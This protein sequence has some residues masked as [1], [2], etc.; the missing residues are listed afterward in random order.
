MAS[1]RR[2]IATLIIGSGILFLGNG[3]LVTLLPVRAQLEGYS[4]TIIGVMGTV[5]FAGFG[6]GC[7]LGPRVVMQVGHIRCFSGFAA[8][9]A[10]SVL[11]YPLALDPLAW[12]LLRG[13]TGLCFAVL[14]MILE[15]WLNEAASNRIRGQ[16]LSLYIIVTNLVTIAGQLMLN[17]YDARHFAL[18]S[19][20]A[21]LVALSLVPLS[22]TPT[23]APKPV[24]LGAIDLRA[25][26]RVS[27]VGFVACLLVGLVEGAFWSLGPV[28]A[29]GRGLGIAEV[30]LFMSMF[31]VGGT[32]AQWPL[33]RLS[34]RLDRRLVI[35]ACCLGAVGTGLAIALL[36]PLSM[37]VRLAL[38]CLHGAFM[39]P[40]YALS[41]AH[42]NDFA[43]NDRLV[44]VS[45]GLLLIYAIGAVLGPFVIAPLMEIY[46]LGTLFVAI[47]AVLGALALYSLYRT[48]RRPLAESVERVD[49]VPVPKTT[50]SVYALEQD[51]PEN[52]TA[53]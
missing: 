48:A 44:E 11:A 16:V 41:L 51:D 39:V 50:P 12:C 35:A 29:Q 20:A 47:A 2:S 34:D 40:L 5:F 10:V 36:P 45:S 43:P 13:L 19:V 6:I 18:F 24:T 42:A 21:V 28:F 22:L 31:V 7:L 26:F 23:A 8:L 9:A 4:T 46:G 25:L 52:G 30:T 27:P 17:L 14:Y 53:P 1:A 32:L 49:F 15:S 33:G 3:L 37:P 38:A